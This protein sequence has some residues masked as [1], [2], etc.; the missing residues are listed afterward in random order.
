M[1]YLVH[2]KKGGINHEVFVQ[3]LLWFIIKILLVQNL[4]TRYSYKNCYGLSYWK[5]CWV[6]FKETYSYKNCYGLSDLVT[7]ALN[8]YYKYSYKNCYGLSGEANWL[9]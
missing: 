3:E 8:S 4:I 7:T 2:N 5:H 1:V 9:A 6:V